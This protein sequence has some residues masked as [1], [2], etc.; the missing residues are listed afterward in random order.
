MLFDFAA[1]N[2]KID[3]VYLISGT[4]KKDK[5]QLI[6]LTKKSQLEGNLQINN[7]DYYFN[8]RLIRI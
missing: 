1:K 4:S 5:H 6:K 2:K 3:V 7:R 8:Q